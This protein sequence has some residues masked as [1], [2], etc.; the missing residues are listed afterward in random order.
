MSPILIR[1]MGLLFLGLTYVIFFKDFSCFVIP[2][3]V[4]ESLDIVW[5][6]LSSEIFRDVSTSV[7][8]TTGSGD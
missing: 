5:P 2:S 7:D 6:L 8:M 1:V 3:E 4:E